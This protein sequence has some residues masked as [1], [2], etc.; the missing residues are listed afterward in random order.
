MMEE[1]GREM[2]IIRPVWSR[3]P[4]PPAYFLRQQEARA[5]WA[6]AGIITGVSLTVLYIGYRIWRRASRRKA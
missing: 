3:Y 6:L 4:E 2:K 1:Q 5:N